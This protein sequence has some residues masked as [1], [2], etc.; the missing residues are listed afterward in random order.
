MNPQEL[1]EYLDYTYK[2]FMQLMSKDTK[3][4]YYKL[5]DE[6]MELQEEGK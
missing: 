3:A 2:R 1:I 4:Q 5:R 6:L